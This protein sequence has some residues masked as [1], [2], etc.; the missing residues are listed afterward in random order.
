M[1]EQ[2]R[3]TRFRV[4]RV[5]RDERLFPAAIGYLASFMAREGI[6]DFAEGLGAF[7]THARLFHDSKGRIEGKDFE[8]QLGE[9]VAVKGRLF[10]TINN[11]AKDSATREQVQRDAQAYR[12]AKDGHNEDAGS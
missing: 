3:L 9:K 4:E 7:L 1:Q 6:E 11:R 10:N 2:P 5:P 12:R 8:A